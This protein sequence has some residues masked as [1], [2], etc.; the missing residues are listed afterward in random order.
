L[1]EKTPHVDKAGTQARQKGKHKELSTAVLI[2]G[3]N[4]FGTT[5]SLA[6]GRTRPCPFAAFVPVVQV[7]SNLK[8]Q[9]EKLGMHPLVSAQ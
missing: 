3:N 7:V 6:Y 4:L 5:Y 9:G 8:T 1:G 2:F